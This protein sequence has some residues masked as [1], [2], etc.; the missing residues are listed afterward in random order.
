SGGRAFSQLVIVP[1]WP[2]AISRRRCR[3]AA[4]HGS[5][6]WARPGRRARLTWPA[7]DPAHPLSNWPVVVAVGA[8][9]GSAADMCGAV[10]P[11]LGE[12]GGAVDADAGGFGVGERESSGQDQ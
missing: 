2:Q 4:V 3:P 1:W 6:G 10:E 12:V 7:R 9:C 8:R 11:V 5:A